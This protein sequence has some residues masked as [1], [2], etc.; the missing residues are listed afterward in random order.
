MSKHIPASESPHAIQTEIEHHVDERIAFY[1]QQT[2]LNRK[3]FR[4]FKLAQMLAAGSVPVVSTFGAAF[5]LHEKYPGVTVSTLA[6]LG[7]LVLVFEAVLQI[8]QY[9][10]LWNS[11][12]VSWEALQEERFLFKAG[13]GKYA[14]I[15]KDDR[16]LKLFAQRAH[17]IISLGQAER[18][19]INRRLEDELRASS[20]SLPSSD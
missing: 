9:Q 2:V 4:L 8:F 14:S 20:I 6:V 16:R 10:S 17:G 3:R 19:S 5:K 15:E 7:F 1:H 18:T 11:Y 12:R 13:T